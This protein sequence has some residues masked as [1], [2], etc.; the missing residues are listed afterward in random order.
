M[1][2]PLPLSK[3][4]P[5]KLHARIVELGTTWAE[6]DGAAS[7]LEE[8]R[9]SVLAQYA[10]KMPGNSATAKDT[11]ALAC[12]PYQDHVRA[13]VAARTKANRLRVEYEAGKQWIE[14]SRSLESTRRAEMTLR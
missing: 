8:T 2:A 1:N 6:A 11:A 9:K 5:D 7:M 12:E 3:Y 4:D 13:M 14:M 10:L